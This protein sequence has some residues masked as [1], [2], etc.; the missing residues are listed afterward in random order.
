MK[1][2]IFWGLVLLISA[3]VQVQA[4]VPKI[5]NLQFLTNPVVIGSWFTITFEFEGNIDKAF[6]QNTWETQSGEMQQDVREYP[7]RPDIKE[8]QKGI[9]PLRW[10]VISQEHKP[11][12]IMKVWVNDKD[13]N[14]SNSLSGEIKL[15]SQLPADSE[16]FKSKERNYHRIVVLSDAHLPG[17]NIPMKQKTIE[18]INSWPDVDM[19]VGLGDIC[20]EFGTV[21]EYAYAKKFFAQLN[22]PFYPIVGNHDYMFEDNLPGRF[23]IANYAIRKKKLERFKETFSLQE[24]FY[25]KRVGPY[26]LIFLS[27][28]HL[29][30][31]NLCEMSGRQIDWWQSELSKNKD[32]P[33]IIF[34][35]A[36]LKGALMGKFRLI[37]D[38]KSGIAQSHRKIHRT[39]LE[40]P[41]IFLWI[42]GHIHLAPTHASF[43]H[44]INTYEQRVGV[45]PNCDMTGG[46]LMS[47]N[48][49]GTKGHNNVWT[50][51]LYLYP[52]KV[53]V[54][55]YDHKNGYWWDELKREIKPSIGGKK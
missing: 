47:E 54:K 34:F 50:N 4:E 15:V 25:S 3:S 37:A 11:Y 8:R 27:T 12:R 13:G 33:T 42:S 40:N 43:N 53:V 20:E 48:D 39:L 44:K 21:E 7:I 29:S 46:S 18:T 22:K 1:K 16:E 23:V 52:E 30:S 28:D 32:V 41:Q 9:L 5:S 26:Q 19:V 31:D 55:T 24:V 6:I 10:K 38:D 17:K 36:P 49:Y 35:H 14:Q 51:S 2:M 45:I